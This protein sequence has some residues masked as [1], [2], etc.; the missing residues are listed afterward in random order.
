MPSAADFEITALSSTVGKGALTLAIYELGNSYRNGWGVKR[1][2][3]AAR[4]HYEVAARLG[5]ADAMAEVGL[6]SVVPTNLDRE[7][8]CYLNGIGCKTDK[9]AA[10]HYY[11]Y[12]RLSAP[13]DI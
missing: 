4:Q 5:D 2:Q 9:K 13:I 1:D 7:A 3:V 11:R 8:Y 10:A 12:S 6:I